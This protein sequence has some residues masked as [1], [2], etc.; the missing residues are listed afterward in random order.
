[1]HTI[2]ISAVGGEL[3]IKKSKFICTAKEVDTKEEAIQFIKQVQKDNN[4]ATHNAYAYRIGNPVLW[5]DSSD[6][7]EPAGTAGVPIMSYLKGKGLTNVAVVVT[8]YYG[9]KKL[10]TGG[11]IRAYKGCA[12]SLIDAV[13]IRALIK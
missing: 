5:E 1:M 12:E 3:K 2:K 4:K 7:G 11:L 10:G 9:G 6:D 13:G 8:R